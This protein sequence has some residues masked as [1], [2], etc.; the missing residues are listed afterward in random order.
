MPLI[1][2]STRAAALLTQKQGQFG[3]LRFARRLRMDYGSDG[4]PVQYDS[5][6]TQALELHGLKIVHGKQIVALLTHLGL[7]PAYGTGTAWDEGDNQNLRIYSDAPTPYSAEPKVRVKVFIRLNHAAKQFLDHAY[8]LQQ[9]LWDSN[10]GARSLPVVLPTTVRATTY[11]GRDDNYHYKWALETESAEGASALR[12]AMEFFLLCG[13]S[14]QQILDMIVWHLHQQGMVH[15]AEVVVEHARSLLAAFD[16]D[17]FGKGRRA[18]H[19]R[20]LVRMAGR[21]GYKE[22]QETMTRNHVDHTVIEIDHRA[23]FCTLAGAGA[24]EQAKLLQLPAIFPLVL[25]DINK[26]TQRE[27][28]TQ[29]CIALRVH[30]PSGL[31]LAQLLEGMVMKAVK[32]NMAAVEHGTSSTATGA[33]NCIA[34]TTQAFLNHHV[35]CLNDDGMLTPGRSPKITVEVTPCGGQDVGSSSL[36]LIL[37]EES[38]AGAEGQLRDRDDDVV[39]IAL[40]LAVLIA[41]RSS[42]APYKHWKWCPIMGAGATNPVCTLDR[43]TV[44]PGFGGG[45]LEARPWI[46]VCADNTNGERGTLPW[47]AMKGNLVS[48]LLEVMQNSEDKPAAEGLINLALCAGG[49]PKRTKEALNAM[50]HSNGDKPRLIIGLPKAAPA[51]EHLD[52][53]SARFNAQPPAFLQILSRPLHPYI[54]LLSPHLHQAMQQRALGQPTSVPFEGLEEIAGRAGWSIPEGDG[55]QPICCECQ[56]A[57]TI[58]TGLECSSA[59]LGGIHAEFAGVTQLKEQLGSARLNFVA[60]MKDGALKCNHC[61]RCM[62]KAVTRRLEQICMSMTVAQA[63]EPASYDALA[64]SVGWTILAPLSTLRRWPDGGGKQRMTL[65][66]PS[67][68]DG[69]GKGDR[70][71]DDDRHEKKRP[72]QDQDMNSTKVKGQTSHP[73]PEGGAPMTMYREP[74]AVMTMGKRLSIIPPAV[75]AIGP[76]RSMWKCNDPMPGKDEHLSSPAI[77]PPMKA[78]D[79][80]P[81][82]DLGALDLAPDPLGDTGQRRGCDDNMGAGKMKIDDGGPRSSTPD[83]Q[84]YVRTTVRDEV[85]HYLGLSADTARPPGLPKSPPPCR[86]RRQQ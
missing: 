44:S 83:G 24:L 75:L 68:E 4:T 42:S 60:D 37:F 55:L 58:G 62:D 40:Q 46:N 48:A 43:V 35:Y 80:G 72:N 20:L 30:P 12:E 71:R 3:S 47:R 15:V 57:Y 2:A 81:R 33:Q 39:L 21:G 31:T 64:A 56:E 32:G 38:A 61:I 26:I 27:K 78:D 45:S 25:R 79:G 29:A 22:I 66:P 70:K 1:Q 6:D 23:Y 69:R 19:G 14:E 34:A 16:P 54:Q 49:P 36:V 51:Q 84:L 11:L 52:G 7:K 59:D 76:V 10:F 73:L 85:L 86:G 18:R 67:L 82:V 77:L 50:K 8:V 41:N 5:N 53:W 9:P 17:R 63:Q 74:P 65:S 28:T 13:V